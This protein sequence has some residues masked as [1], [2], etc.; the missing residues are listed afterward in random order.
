MFTKQAAAVP[1]IYN[2][3]F[4]Q[5]FLG[6]EANT[7]HT[8]FA[9]DNRELLSVVAVGVERAERIYEPIVERRARK[10]LANSISDFD[11]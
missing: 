2:P 10:S 1:P 11:L 9:D 8:C 3:R 4:L 7:S 5:G 6:K